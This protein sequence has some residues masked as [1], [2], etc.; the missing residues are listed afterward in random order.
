MDYIYAELDPNLLPIAEGVLY[1]GSC[2]EIPT[3]ITFESLNTTPIDA[4]LVYSGFKL[5]FQTSIYGQYEVFIY[6]EEFGE[7]DSITSTDIGINAIGAWSKTTITYQY[8][9]YTAYYTT[10]KQYQDVNTLIFKFKEKN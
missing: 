7:L 3:E 1:Y 2:N 8:I 6:P 4:Q 10:L 9:N 5:P